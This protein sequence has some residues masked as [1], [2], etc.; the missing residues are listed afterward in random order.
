MLPLNAEVQVEDALEVVTAN[1]LALYLKAKCYHLN[2]TG[3]RFYGDHKTYDGIAE[4]ATKW[5]DTF[6][7]RMR[8]LGVMVPASSD[9]IEENELFAPGALDF[10]AEEMAEDI[11]TSME[12]FS[13]YM[14]T[15]CNDLDDTTLNSVQE[16]DFELGRHI[17]FVRSSL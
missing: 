11:L 10:N 12:N 13:V 8:T 15:Q 1:T 9:W 6:A 17:Y 16:F 3:P 5:F 2:V 4:A 7:E 14:Q